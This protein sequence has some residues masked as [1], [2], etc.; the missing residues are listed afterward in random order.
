M[1]MF[2]G[3]VSRYCILL[4]SEKNYEK[5]DRGKACWSSAIQRAEQHGM[6]ALLLCSRPWGL[7]IWPGEEKQDEVVYR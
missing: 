7:R 3:E 2:S 4:L 5:V 6:H 1:C